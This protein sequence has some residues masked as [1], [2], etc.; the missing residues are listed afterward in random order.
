MKSQPTMAPTLASTPSPRS[1]SWRAKSLVAV[2]LLAHSVLAASTPPATAAT[3]VDEA[4]R[5]ARLRL[6]VRLV[7][8]R[9]ASESSGMVPASGRRP[10]SSRRAMASAAVVATAAPMAPATS[11]LPYL[12]LPGVTG[13]TSFF[14]VSGAK[15]LPT[16]MAR[17]ASVSLRV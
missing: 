2:V 1:R 5:R 10:A 6:V 17:L 12:P 4:M 7:G 14:R 11:T 15:R 13:S 16:P 8:R 3:L 9:A